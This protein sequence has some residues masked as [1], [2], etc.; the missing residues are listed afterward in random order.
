VPPPGASKVAARELSQPLEHRLH[1]DHAQRRDAA[2][3]V[4]I[5]V[6]QALSGSTHRLVHD[7]PVRT[8]CA[9]CSREGVG[10]GPRLDHERSART[11]RSSARGFA[12]IFPN[13]RSS[14]AERGAR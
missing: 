3:A 8:S 10:M 11:S 2:L 12:A 5:D 14:I 9:L 1:A 6:E 13:D 4:I 7:R